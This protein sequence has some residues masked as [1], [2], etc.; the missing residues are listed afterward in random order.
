MTAGRS[1]ALL[2]IGNVTI[3]EAIQPDGARSVAT[4]GDVLYAALA[5]RA[6]LERVSW[7]APVGADLP[8]SDLDEIAAA[9]VVAAD[10]A[11]RALPTVRN[12]ITYHRDGSRV[13]DLIHGE[14]HFDAM[15]VHPGDVGPRMLASDGILVS[16][17]SL[18]S[19]VALVPW[20]RRNTA[21]TIYLDLQEDY[22]V[23]NE[24][25]WLS[26]IGSCDVFMPSEIEAVALA[27]TSDLDRAIRMFRSLGPGVVVIKRAEHGS[28]VLEA[29]G[30]TV[31]EVPAERV[32][33]S[34]STGAGDAFCGAFAAVHLA[35]GDPVRAARAASAT[36]AVAIGAPGFLGLLDH[37]RARR[38]GVHAG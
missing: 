34:D 19:Q 20:L 11:R 8:E 16:A 28:L 9:G 27:G 17:M 21:A 5:A 2:C 37:A 18:R 33:A 23:G 31:V 36:A 25:T 10:P 32:R 29:G 15:S 12:L 38:A 24:A 26:V 13:W 3:D 1:P 4:G 6:H 7:L 35:G 30:D 22:I 14:D